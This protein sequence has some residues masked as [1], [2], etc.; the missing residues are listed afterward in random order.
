M[1][2]AERVGGK[3]GERVKGKGEGKMGEV[4]EGKSQWG[5]NL[6]WSTEGVI[7]C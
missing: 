6:C 3:E 1:D 4:S 7:G 5:M 2:V